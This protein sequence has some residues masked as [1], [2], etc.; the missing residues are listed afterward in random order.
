VDVICEI[1]RV[2]SWQCTLFD[3][4][5]D[6]LGPEEAEGAATTLFAVR[7]RAPVPTALWLVESIG[8]GRE[9][10]AAH[11]WDGTHKPAWPPPA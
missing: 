2:E 11:E 5:F 3:F 1:S 4:D 6:G 10:G 8:V 9:H 7:S